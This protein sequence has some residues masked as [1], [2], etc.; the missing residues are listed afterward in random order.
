MQYLD[1]RVLWICM[2]THYTFEKKLQLQHS[3]LAI[4]MAWQWRLLFFTFLLLQ[5][6]VSPSYFN[7]KLLSFSITAGLIEFHI[8][9]VF[10]DLLSCT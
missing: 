9:S 8:T 6:K 1:L 7:W 2:N 4:A 10:G 5:T 3:R